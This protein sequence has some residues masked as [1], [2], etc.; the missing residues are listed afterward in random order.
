MATAYSARAT[1]FAGVSTPV[2]WDELDAGAHPSDF[3]IRTMH[4]RLRSVGDLWAAL[5]NARGVS[6]RALITGRPVYI[7]S[8]RPSARAAD[9]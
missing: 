4:A 5:R 2:R 9:R 3:T 7:E 1:S 8:S 6:P